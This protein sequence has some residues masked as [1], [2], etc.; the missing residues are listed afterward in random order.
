MPF[1]DKYE[2][3]SVFSATGIFGLRNF[4][5]GLADHRISI[6]AHGVSCFRNSKIRVRFDF[7]TNF[8]LHVESF[9]SLGIFE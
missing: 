9:V 1:Q 8:R 5:K 2:S 6:V 4:F 7:S 3:V